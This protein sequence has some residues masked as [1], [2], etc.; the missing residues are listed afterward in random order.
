MV[1]RDHGLVRLGE[2]QQLADLT[3]HAAGIDENMHHLSLPVEQ[4]MI[5]R[6]CEAERGTLS[7]H[8]ETHSRI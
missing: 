2:E 4:S 7:A 8:S 5:Q 3:R 1:C 6:V